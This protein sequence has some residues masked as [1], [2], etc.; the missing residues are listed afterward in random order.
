MLPENFLAGGGLPCP[1][2]EEVLLD[3]LVC[4]VEIQTQADL[5]VGS[6]QN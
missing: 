6:R 4:G 1:I 2:K 5:E 3:C